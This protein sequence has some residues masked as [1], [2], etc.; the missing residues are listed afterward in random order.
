MLNFAKLM[1]SSA[2]M[3]NFAKPTG[4]GF[5]IVSRS[6]KWIK[7]FSALGSNVTTHRSP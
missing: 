2:V 5:V 3:P 4:T 1:G 7:M 6:S